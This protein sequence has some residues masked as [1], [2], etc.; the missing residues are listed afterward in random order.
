MRRL[1]RAVARGTHSDERTIA[2]GV[3]AV[4]ASVAALTLVHLLSA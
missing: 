3:V 1:F 4:G 2:Y